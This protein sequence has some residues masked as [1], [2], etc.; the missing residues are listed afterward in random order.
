MK[1]GR[2]VTPVVAT[3]AVV[4]IG[5]VAVALV[6]NG[7]VASEPSDEPDPTATPVPDSQAGTQGIPT[8]DLVEQPK[9]VELVLPEIPSKAKEAALQ[10]GQTGTTGRTA[11][12]PQSQGAGIHMGRWRQDSYCPASGRPVCPED[13]RN[14]SVG[15]RASQGCGRQHS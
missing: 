11:P 15:R 14:L 3:I 7:V 1:L 2:V 4:A 6:A 5:V 9:E 8:L 12:P 10:T 13:L